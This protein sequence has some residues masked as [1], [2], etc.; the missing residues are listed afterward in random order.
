[1]GT[2][3]FR[4]VDTD[5]W[6]CANEGFQ[7]GK[8]HLLKSIK[9]RRKSN[10]TNN[11]KL[12]QARA[13]PLFN[14]P[15]EKPGLEGEVERLKKEQ[16]MLRVE[17]LKLTQQHEGHQ[18][19]LTNV[20]ERVRCKELKQFH[21]LV[22][23]TGIMAK[24]PAFVEQLIHKVKGKGKE[25]DEVDTVKRHRLL[26]TQ[27]CPFDCND[28]HQGYEQLAT[29]QSKLIEVLLSDTVNSNSMDPTVPSIVR[30]N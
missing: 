4:K 27:K 22:F 28:R 13:A 2:Q 8:K 12:I 1:M 21:M 16:N 18:V 26:G 10:T 30:N 25:L 9:R 7:G 29:L 23:L 19:Q 15:I 3:G 17:I 11:N 20:E 6:E 5:R 14:Y 24:R